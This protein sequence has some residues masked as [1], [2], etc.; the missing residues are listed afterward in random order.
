MSDPASIR[1]Q[2]KIKTGVVNRLIKEN[3]LYRKE[4]VAQKLKVDKFVADG[5]EDWDIKNGRKMLEESEKMITDSSDRLGKA[6]ADLRGLLTGVRQ[7]PQYAADPEFLNAE[8]A[9]E[10]ASV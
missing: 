9:L 1:R 7:D 10:M 4:C 6:V 3:Q 2:L 8:G 5:A